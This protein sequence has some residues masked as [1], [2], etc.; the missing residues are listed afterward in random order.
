MT[1]PQASVITDEMQAQ[2]GVESE[3]AVVEL[4]KSACRLFARAVGYSDP[5]FFDEEFAKRL[6]YRGIV[7]PPAF[8]GHLVYNPNRP[9]RP[10]GYFRFDT[11]YKRVLNGG[12][13]IEHF[14]TV[15][16]GDLLTVTT[17]L[18]D[19]QERVGSVGPMLISVTEFIYRDQS[20]KVVAVVRG[21]GIQY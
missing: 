12:T 18:V 19:L 7:A 6:G 1:Q 5:V 8:L 11:P 3:P 2:I 16:A 15:C 13:E 17:K 4:D 21:T 10:G 20:G 14:D 9:T